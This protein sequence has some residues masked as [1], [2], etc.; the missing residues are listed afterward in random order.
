[1]QNVDNPWAH[2]PLARFNPTRTDNL[3]PEWQAVVGQVT[4]WRYAGTQDEGQAYAGQQTWQ[5]ADDSGFPFHWV[6]AEDLE[7]V[8]S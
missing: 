3:R 1:M 2:K 5:A 7:E 8:E 6:P 4:T